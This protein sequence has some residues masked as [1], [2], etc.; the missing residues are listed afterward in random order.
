VRPGAFT[1]IE[2]LVTISIIGI[3]AGMLLP[4]LGKAKEKGRRA[5]CLSNLHQISLGMISYADDFHGVFPTGPASAD[6]SDPNVLCLTSETGIAAGAPNNVGGFTCYARYLVKHAYVPSTAVFV[7]PSD[8]MNGDSKTPCFVAVED[9]TH[10]AWQKMQWNNISYFYIT[11]LTVNLPTKGSSQ[12]RIYM[13]MADRANKTSHRTPD[14]T[15]ADNHGVDG[16]NVLCTDGHVE[17]KNGSTVSDLYQVI[18]DD[19]GQYHVDKG[20]LGEP[21]TVGQAP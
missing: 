4:V 20:L 18:H 3:L 12:G 13:L 10:Q 19:W 5:V 15:S 9:A 16:R 21:Q 14:L 8:R 11:R 1:L 2:L 17:W 6:L 7:C